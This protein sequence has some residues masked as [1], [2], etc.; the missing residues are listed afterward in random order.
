MKRVVSIGLVLMLVLVP[1]YIMAFAA[2]APDIPNDRIVL[3]PILGGDWAAVRFYENGRFWRWVHE[4]DSVLI[5]Q[6]EHLRQEIRCLMQDGSTLSFPVSWEE[7]LSSLDVTMGGQTL[8]GRVVPPDG[9]RFLDEAMD[10]VPFNILP[11][12]PESP[13]YTLNEDNIIIAL[14]PGA[15]GLLRVGQPTDSLL[16]YHDGDLPTYLDLT[17]EGL[18]KF[19]CPMDWGTQAL[20]TSAPGRTQLT[21]RL[22]LP[23]NI[24]LPKGFV[25]PVYPVTVSEGK[26]IELSF[27]AGKD[28]MGNPRFPW[29]W[30]VPKPEEICLYYSTDNGTTWIDDTEAQE[31]EDGEERF[32]FYSKSGL[33]IYGADF[34]FFIPYR[35]QENTTYTVYLSYEGRASNLLHI[36]TDTMGYSSYTIGGDRD[37]SVTPSEEFPDTVQPGPKPDPTPKPKP[38]PEPEPLEPESTPEPE[39]QP[40]FEPKPNPGDDPTT[41]NGPVET[42]VII[43]SEQPPQSE[44]PTTPGP[45]PDVMEE[46]PL[47]RVT[48]TTTILS[49][50]RLREMLAF[51]DSTILFEKQGI[52]VE[53]SADFLQ[54]LSLQDNQ[55]LEVR[56]ERPEATAFR[57]SLFANGQE[58]FDLP[59]T[60]VRV[61]LS[62][63]KGLA[64]YDAW[65]E[66]V[67]EAPWD[68]GSKTV[69]CTITATGTYFLRQSPKAE[70]ASAAGEAS[71]EPSATPPS[72]PTPIEKNALPKSQPWPVWGALGLLPV[73]AVGVPLFLRRRRGG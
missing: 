59:E 20:N 66:C 27:Y 2:D 1:M 70:P 67:S 10:A 62:D 50:A 53:L 35:A 11:L 39:P 25:E 73:A 55:L 30:K 15:A 56:I 68:E 48:P 57:L 26:F 60:G 12:Y 14:T 6:E 31:D 23:A 9:F 16:D 64:L 54:D 36:T 43:P 41:S 38:T 45:K 22:L 37:G 17:L 4:A 69:R 46:P 42:P 3:K 8:I 18:G 40:G 72:S 51:G 47:E 71:P 63:G 44:L 49:G 24:I 5:K 65:G 19:T 7:A 28:R 13:S 32:H 58:I 61:P 34:L 21:G 52:A 29:L 33:F